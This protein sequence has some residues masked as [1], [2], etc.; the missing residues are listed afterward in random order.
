LTLVPLHPGTGQA[1]Q[2]DLGIEAE[3]PCIDQRW[4]GQRHRKVFHATTFA[5]RL[6]L[7]SAIACTQVETGASPSFSHGQQT[8]VEEHLFVPDGQRQAG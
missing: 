8:V 1:T 6:P 2:T 5:G 7:W 4:V 3:V